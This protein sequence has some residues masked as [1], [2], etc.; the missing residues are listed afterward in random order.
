MK[1][2]K[3]KRSRCKKKEKRKSGEEEKGMERFCAEGREEEE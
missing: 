3:K 1:G 2:K